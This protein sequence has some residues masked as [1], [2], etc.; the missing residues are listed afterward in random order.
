M[1]NFIK[2][3]ASKGSLGRRSALHGVGINDAQYIVRTKVDGRFIES[4]AYSKWRAMIARCYDKD[5]HA[6]QPTYKD[7]T[8]C[9][10]WLTFS[11]FE[12]W[13]DDNNIDEYQLDKDIKIKGNKVYGPDTC[14]FVPREINNLLNKRQRLNR[15]LPTGVAKVSGCKTYKAV[16]QIDGKTTH[17]GCFKSKETARDAYIERKNSEIKRKMK[18]YP[19][20]ALFL[21]SHILKDDSND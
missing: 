19:E 20:F 13:F 10:D 21:C 1:N 6:R 18:Q 17:I 8:V 4:P 9:S 11:N 5:F 2:T 15:L 3:P 16:I 7:A 14:L 12:L